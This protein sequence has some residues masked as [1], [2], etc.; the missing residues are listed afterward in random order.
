[1]KKWE[2][3]AEVRRTM[4]GRAIVYTD[5]TSLG[6]SDARL[7]TAGCGVYVCKG[8]PWQASFPLPG[9]VQSSEVAEARAL[10]HAVE[11]GTNDKVDVQVCL[12]NKSVVD[13]ATAILGGQQN[14]PEKS[15]G[16]WRRI[17]EA[18]KRRK[19]EGGKGHEVKWVPGHL[20]VDDVAKGRTTEEDRV[21]NLNTDTLAKA[22]AATNPCPG[23]LSHAAKCRKKLAAVLLNAYADMALERRMRMKKMATQW[24]EDDDEE[25]DP[26]AEEQPDAKPRVNALGLQGVRRRQ[27]VETIEEPSNEDREE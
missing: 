19:E 17:N 26:W 2:E 12:D 23:H 22:G 7:R 14:F 1:M 3:T 5:G 9:H 11:A 13:T 10:T 6:Q 15:A 21:G 24:E 4:E 18:N 20:S 25:E 27:E 16:L 8:H